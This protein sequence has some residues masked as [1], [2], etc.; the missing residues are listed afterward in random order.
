MRILISGGTGSLGHALVRHYLTSSKDTQIV[1]LSRD[2]LK[3]SVM[4]ETF[5]DAR[6][7]FF[8]GDV[9]DLQRLELAFRAGIDTVIHAAALKRVDSVCHDPDEVLKTNIE[10]SR[11]VLHAAR[12][13]VKRVLLV[14]SDKAC[15]PANAYGVSKAMAEH[16]TTSFNVYGYPAG[17]MSSV[18]RYGNVLGSRG[19]VVHTWREQYRKGLPLTLTHPDMTRFVIT[20][21]Q[22]VAAIEWALGRMEGG[23]VYVPRL[24]AAL[25]LDLACAIAGTDEYPATLSGLRP[26]GEKMYETL[27]TVEELGRASRG[28]TEDYFTLRPYLH[29]W[30]AAWPHAGMIREQAEY[31]SD[32]TRLLTVDQLTGLLNVVPTEGV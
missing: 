31:R 24:P 19:S 30:R 5:P 9:R 2:E 21:P 15:H 13:R 23:E 20:M 11:N 22:A 7:D 17:T 29:P 18:I 16:L 12:G 14:S 6:L 32:T 4:R 26:G 10:G 27:I 8:L 25:M 3:Q 1:V 28:V